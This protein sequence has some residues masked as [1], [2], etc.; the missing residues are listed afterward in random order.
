MKKKP[1]VTWQ[2]YM[3]TSDDEAISAS[4][5]SKYGH[6][7][8]TIKRYSAIVLAGPL[9]LADLALIGKVQAA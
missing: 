8:S 6:L 1:I 4:F 2:G 5:Q 9:T 7:P 3:A